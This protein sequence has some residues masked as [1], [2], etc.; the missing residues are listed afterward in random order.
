MIVHEGVTR[1]FGLWLFV[2]LTNAYYL[3][4]VQ[5]SWT[6]LVPVTTV[7]QVT[8]QEFMAVRVTPII[9]VWGGTIGIQLGTCVLDLSAYPW[10]CLVHMAWLRCVW[11]FLSSFFRSLLP[12]LLPF[13][14][15]PSA[16]LWLCLAL[17]GSAWLHSA[18]LLG[19][20]FRV[21]C[22]SVSFKCFLWSQLSFEVVGWF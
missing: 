9:I 12:A 17:L 1:C 20:L 15:L 13:T 16:W 7:V 8:A 11:S 3:A 21:Q 6:V 19:P 5:I 10:L 2:L 18:Q 14:S 22:F 4:P